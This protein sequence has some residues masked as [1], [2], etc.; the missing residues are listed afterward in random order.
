VQS[1][2][3]L[4][5]EET[6]VQNPGSFFRLGFQVSGLMQSLIGFRVSSSSYG[7]QHE[8]GG[9]CLQNS[10][11]LIF[12]AAFSASRIRRLCILW[13]QLFLLIPGLRWSRRLQCSFFRCRGSLQS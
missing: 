5:E 1:K 13:H 8:I 4:V 9:G 6:R 10:V 2:T 7:F 11:V 12:L 3:S